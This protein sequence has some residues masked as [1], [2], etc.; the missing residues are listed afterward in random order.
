MKKKLIICVY[1][2]TVIVLLFN[3]VFFIKDELFF[4]LNDLPEGQL[5]YSSMSPDNNRSLSVYR[6]KCSLG[7]GIRAELY[8]WDENMQATSKNVF[9]DANCENAIVCWADNDVISINDI[10]LNIGEGNTYD[11]RRKTAISQAS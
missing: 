5:L 8:E 1:F 11:S 4:N 9:W 2:L 6:V 10:P 7:T 3:S